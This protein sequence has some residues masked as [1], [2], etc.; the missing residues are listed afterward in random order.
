MRNIGANVGVSLYVIFGPAVIHVGNFF[1][2]ANLFFY[3][4][5]LSVGNRF[6]AVKLNLGSV[7]RK[8]SCVSCF[9]AEVY[10]IECN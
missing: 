3:V 9:W 10:I 5:F 1:V 8:V 2:E 4:V 7:D 6:I